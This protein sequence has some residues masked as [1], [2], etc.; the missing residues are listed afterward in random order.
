MAIISIIQRRFHTP[1]QGV[2][3]WIGICSEM[4]NIEIGNNSS[5][6]E[7]LFDVP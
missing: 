5:L 4:S 6:A 7:D 1:L 2:A 3:I